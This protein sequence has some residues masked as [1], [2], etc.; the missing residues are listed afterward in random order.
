MEDT[1]QSTTKSQRDNT[2]K[3]KIPKKIGLKVVRGGVA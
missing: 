3:S 2:R 1:R